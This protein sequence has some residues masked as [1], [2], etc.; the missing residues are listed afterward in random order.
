M[1]VMR[2]TILRVPVGESV[3]TAARR[4]AADLLEAPEALGHPNYEEFSGDGN[5]IR[6]GEV[7][8]MVSRSALAPVGGGCRVF[9]LIEAERMN[10][11]AANLLLKTIEEPPPSLHVILA[12]TRPYDLPETIRSRCAVVETAATDHEAVFR[13]ADFGT[14]DARRLA[15]LAGT[16]ERA[17][18]V[19]EDPDQRDL[20][21]AWAAL[22]GRLTGLPATA[23]DFP[24][25]IERL[26]A[27][28]A[29]GD[30]EARRRQRRERTD[31]LMTGLAILGW[32]YREVLA[33]AVGA[34]PLTPPVE[35]DL[36]SGVT[37]RLAATMGAAGA[38]QALKRI[39]ATR[40]ALLA[41]GSPRLALESLFLDLGAL[42]E[43]VDG[44]LG[45]RSSPS[46]PE[47]GD[48]NATRRRE[49]AG[50]PI[51]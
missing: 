33:R 51:K 21:E 11:E 4:V 24:E 23:L 39:E 1:E 29:T 9:A 13:A 19:V 28:P 15:F 25:P 20:L 30:D 6:A 5:I 41:N 18:A 31:H 49:A 2:S 3:A 36:G 45:G 47:A 26:V 38:T 43:R 27:A 12:T 40:E 37:T 42:S 44:G 46:A 16:T 48:P 10:D 22:P 50:P 17:K 32:A 35:A 14:E 34:D 7:A 8:P